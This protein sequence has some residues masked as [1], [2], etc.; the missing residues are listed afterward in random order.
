MESNTS[1]F[2]F[3]ELNKF[4]VSQAKKKTH[5]HICNKC[6]MI[7]CFNNKEKIHICKTC[8]NRSDFKYIE[9]PYSCKLAF[10]EL[11]TMNIAPRIICE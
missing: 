10:Q 3:L 6:G 4:F 1:L 11:L 2:S 7:A 5:L 9:I 8:E